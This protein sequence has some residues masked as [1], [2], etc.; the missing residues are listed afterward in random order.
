MGERFINPPVVTELM[1]L[2]NDYSRWLKRGKQRAAV[3]R[4]LHKPM[5]TVE[6]CDAARQWAPRLQLRDVWFLMRQMAD[7]GL[8]APLNERSNNGRLYALTDSG[9]RAVAAAFGASVT[10]RPNS[11]D[12]RLYS[13]VVR[14]RIR[15]RV[16]VGL[17]EMEKRAPDGQTA[18]NI[19]K[20]IRH[21]YPV[22][23]NPVIRAVRELADKKLIICAGVTPLRGC[24]LYRLAP[25]GRAIV[26]QLQQ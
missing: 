18:S 5:T 7:K 14:A 23:L 9:R 25:A 22:G 3:A 1:S 26:Q 11:I 19:R 16:L 20:F 2:S 13:W 4:V 15:K 17:V 21:D 6:I 8:A 24:R 10:A 12:W